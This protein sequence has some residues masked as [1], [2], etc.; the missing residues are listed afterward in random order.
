MRSQLPDR[1]ERCRV[2]SGRLASTARDGCN[3]AFEMPG[4]CG[5][6]LLVIASAGSEAVPWEHASVS[7]RRRN[8]NWQEMSWVKDAFWNEEEC[9]VQYHPPRSHYVNLH[10]HTLH[11]WRP[12]DGVFPMPPRFAV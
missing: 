2:V 5:E 12:V 6:R 7:T 8:P 4:P 1:V 10:P 3:G 9:V 11:L